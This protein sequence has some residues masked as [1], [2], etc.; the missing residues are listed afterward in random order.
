[1]L[2]ARNFYCGLESFFRQGWKSCFPIYG[3]KISALAGIF[4]R[5]RNMRESTASLNEQAA[6]RPGLERPAFTG[7]RSLK[8]KPYRIIARR[9]RITV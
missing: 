8:I 9:L 6:I 7:A 1:V 3:P 5:N 4:W 2:R